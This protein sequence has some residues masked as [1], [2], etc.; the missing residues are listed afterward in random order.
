LSRK[1][2]LHLNNAV[3]L[4]EIVENNMDRQSVQCGNV[5]GERSASVVAWHSGKIIG[6]I[7]EV[8]LGRARLEL[9]WVI[10]FSG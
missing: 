9:G 4:P 6:H 10:I 3:N 5:S 8:S 2:K 7:N 1:R